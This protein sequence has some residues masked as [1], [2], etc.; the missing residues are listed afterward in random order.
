[1]AA[2][3]EQQGQKPVKKERSLSLDTQSLKALAPDNEVA[4]SALEMRQN[5]EKFM[6]AGPQRDQLIAQLKEDVTPILK[7]ELDA[8]QA[9]SEAKQVQQLQD[10][11]RAITDE[12]TGAQAASEQDRLLAEAIDRAANQ[13]KNHLGQFETYGPV[14]EVST[15]EAAVIEHLRTVLYDS[16]RGRGEFQI[17]ICQK[18]HKHYSSSRYF[19]PSPLVTF[20][21]DKRTSEGLSDLQ[22]SG[23]TIEAM[24]HIHGDG[25]SADPS[26]FRPADIELA[27]SLQMMTDAGLVHSYL[28]T[29]APDNILIAYGPNQKEKLP[30]GEAVGV[31]LPD[32]SFDV[33]NEKYAGVFGTGA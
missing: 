14:K 10:T 6:P 29:P 15:V 31:F 21:Y 28:L 19:E 13:I 7:P 9:I 30:L 18:D 22:M 24:V 2:D 1:M 11:A 26:H 3:N 8:K 20:D 27:D 25:G 4:R 32:G 5:L 23:Y 12:A 33:R 16:R 17:A